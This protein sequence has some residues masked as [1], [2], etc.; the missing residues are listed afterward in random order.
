MKNLGENFNVLT[1][2]KF[3]GQYFHCLVSHTPDQLR[4]VANTEKVGRQFNFIK[5]TTKT[6][7]CQSCYFKCI[8]KNRSIQ[9]FKYI[10]MNI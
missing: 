9:Q 7:N 10:I 4:I 3:Y 5:T 1:M 8:S 2:Q 6:L